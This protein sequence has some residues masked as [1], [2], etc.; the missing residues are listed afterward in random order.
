MSFEELCA[1]VTA[2]AEEY[3]CEIL[4]SI[5][6]LEFDGPDG[7]HGPDPED[8]QRLYKHFEVYPTPRESESSPEGALI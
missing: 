6:D 3:Q 7:S 1:I 4:E 2:Y 8:L 5:Q